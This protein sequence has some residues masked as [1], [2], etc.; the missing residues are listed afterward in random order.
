[1]ARE[2]D[3]PR[4]ARGR[5]SRSALLRAARELI[6]ERGVEAVTMAAVAER[7][8]VTR[9]AVY[10]HFRSRG[11][12]INELFGH[13]ADTEDLP[14]RFAAVDDAPDG[15]AALEEFARAHAAF[16]ARTLPFSTAVERV[17]HADPD[18]ARHWETVLYW[19]NET[20]KAL[21]RRL[22]DEGVLAPGWTV[23]TAADMLL[24]LTS[25]GVIRTLLERGWS[26]EQVGA[27]MARVLRAA[28]TAG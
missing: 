14:G 11:E 17:A 27:H 15:V 5:R 7:A 21:I 12:L 18:A 3:A 1:M 22:H 20:N 13:I 6:E 16:M 8:G 10:L 19:R 24:A 25:N 26:V 23:D 2:I 9:R 4:N 28:F